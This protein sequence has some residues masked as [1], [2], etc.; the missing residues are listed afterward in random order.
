MHADRVHA[1]DCEMQRGETTRWLLIV[2]IGAECEEKLCAVD[3][4]R[5][6]Q[7]RVRGRW[8]EAR[9]DQRGKASTVVTFHV[10]A[11]TE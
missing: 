1:V 10:D 9:V 4:R 6:G 11:G 8:T 7:W 5:V 2:D 3:V